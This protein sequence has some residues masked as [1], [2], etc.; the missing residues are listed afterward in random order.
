M[1]ILKDILSESNDYYIN[2]KKQIQKRLKILPIGSIKRR[3]ISGK[4]YYYLQYRSGKKVIQKYLGR[5]KPEA[6]ID[7]IN[8]RK[9]LKKELKK[10]NESLKVIKRSRGRKR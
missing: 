2:A 7:K 8:E 6:I 3:K 4:E 5:K 1:E 9:S 10:V